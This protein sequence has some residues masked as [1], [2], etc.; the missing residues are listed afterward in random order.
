M[1]ARDRS[2]FAFAERESGRLPLG[3]GA[4]AG[5]SFDTDRGFLADELGFD[6]VAPNSIDAVS[7]GDVPH[8]PLA[9]RGRAGAVVERRVRLLRA[10]G[11]V[12]RGLLDHAAEEEPGRGR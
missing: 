6:G 2:P 8:P 12:E 7:G 3:A 11:C 10:A 4:L 5:V 9:P 1:L